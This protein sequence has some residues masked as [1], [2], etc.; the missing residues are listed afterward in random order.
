MSPDI[1]TSIRS[2]LQ[3]IPATDFRDGHLALLRTLG[4]ESSKTRHPR[5]P[6]CHLSRD[7]QEERTGGDF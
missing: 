4:Y 7:S 1:Q 3:A 6:T 2:A 5:C